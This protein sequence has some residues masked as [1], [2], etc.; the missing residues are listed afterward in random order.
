MKKELKGFI[1]GLIVS[2]FAVS[3]MAYARTGAEM[4]E[5]AYNNVKIYI[6]GVLLDPKDADGNTVEPFVSN[7]TTYLPVRAIA[8]AFG[9]DV[10]WDAET[11]SVMLGSR[12]YDW[13][14]QMSPIDFETTGTRDRNTLATLEVESRMT[15]GTKCN[16]GLQFYLYNDINGGVNENDD[17]TVEC[18]YK[19]S[20]LLDNNYSDFEGIVADLDHSGSGTAQIKFYGDGQLIYSSPIISTGTNTTDFKVDVSG[21][22]TLQ[23]CVESISSYAESKAVYPC[24]AEA[25]LLKK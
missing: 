16:R 6:D 22:T 21:V 17:G 4:I 11:S 25:R 24:I 7:G 8:N 12:N 2:A 9:K 23:I 10:N 1:I 19:V 5:A 14:D 15:D 18:F 13:L 3:G 20:Y